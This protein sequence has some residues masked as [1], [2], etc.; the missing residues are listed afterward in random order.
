MLVCEIQGGAGG[1][2]QVVLGMAA[3]L[4]QLSGDSDEQYHFLTLPDHDAWLRP[5]L[6]DNCHVLTCRQK[7]IPV[8]I[9]SSRVPEGVHIGK[10]DGTLEE[11]GCDLVHF[12]F[13][14]ALITNVPSI[15][16]P[17]DLQHLHLP[18]FFTEEQHRYRA[19]AYNFFAQQAQLVACTS[20]WIRDDFIKR[21]AL[22]PEKIVVIP[23][24]PPVEC[25]PMP[26]AKEIALCRIYYDLPDEFI[27]FPAHTWPHKNHLA[28]IEA[29][30]LLK[31]RGL[32]IPCVFSGKESEFSLK[33]KQRVSTRKMDD[34]V[35]FV[36]FV[37]P[38]ELQCLYRSATAL[39]L[40]TL[41]EAASFPVWEA[42]YAGIPVACS[43]VTSLP[44]QVGDAALI[45]DP[46]DINDMARVIGKLWTDKRLQVQLVQRGKEQLKHF[47]W[48]ETALRFRAQYR[49]LAHRELSEED[50]MLLNAP[51]AL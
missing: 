44:E 22:P 4:G 39:V 18:Q 40:P 42:F 9:C 17:H 6:G 38:L 41:F 27:F 34:Q 30:S 51:S 23:W 8:E 28:L 19:I 48:K 47:S 13:Q 29:L 20:N 3:G 21:L 10:S 50:H 46:R 36:G 2:Q 35:H 45:F 33:I 32:R 25:Y 1:V 43:N 11:S 7:D 14:S 15:Y 37:S 5:Y 12:T 31:Q 24:A 26:T 16:H 49:K